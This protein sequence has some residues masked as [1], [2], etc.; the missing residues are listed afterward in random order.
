MVLSSCQDSID[1]LQGAGQSR[2]SSTHIAW[3]LQETVAANTEKESSSYVALLD[4]T[5]AFDTAWIQGLFVKLYDKMDAKIWRIMYNFYSDFECAVQIGGKL[6]EW[7]VPGQGVYQGQPWAMFLY[8]KMIDGLMSSLRANAMG[9]KIGLKYCG[10]PAYADD[11]AIVTLHKPLLQKCL[12]IAFEYSQKWRFE[13]NSSKTEI[14]IFGKDSC[15]NLSLHLGPNALTISSG[16]I[17]MGIPLSCSNDFELKH[18]QD[19]IDSGR[20]AY[21]SVQGLGNKFYPVPPPVASKLYWAISVPRMTHGLEATCL[22]D[23]AVTMLEQAHGQ[24]A[25]GIQGLPPQTPNSICI[26]SLGWVSMEAIIDKLRLLFL[27]RILLMSTTCIYK[28]VAI[29]RIHHYFYEAAE[30][31]SSSRSPLLKMIQTYRKYDL[32][33]LLMQSLTSGSYMTIGQ[34]RKLVI[35]KINRLDNLRF[36]MTCMTYKYVEEFS[37][38][39]P[40]LA[41]WPWWVFG[42]KRPDKCRDCKIL[43]RLLFG[44]SS[45]NVHTS[46]YKDTN[47]TLCSHCE[48]RCAQT[49]AHMLYDCGNPL[50][51]LERDKW[52]MAIDKIVP[53]GLIISLNQ[54]SSDEKTQLILSGLGGSYVSE[55]EHVFVVMLDFSC[56][57]YRTHKKL[58]DM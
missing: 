58:L 50:L 44:E 15:P 1:E 20:K 29:E 48:V 51:V 55:L 5:K 26:A 30:L 36:S 19:R 27:W 18:V 2:S 52:K 14:I 53:H 22:S 21:F 40:K 31:E 28:Q 34:F 32:L 6:S 43:A 54:M 10:N 37:N 46:R 12:N 17:H 35:E 49:A 4:T 41:M 45:L 8:M 38:C 57:M 42:S 3:L 16:G 24:M 9:A 23:K 13:F 39:V 56:S 47:S 25:K 33:A 11:I 7:F